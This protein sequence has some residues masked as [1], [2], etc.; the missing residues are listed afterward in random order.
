M[1]EWW[2]ALFIPAIKELFSHDLNCVFVGGVG[3]CLV[4][5]GLPLSWNTSN[6]DLTLPKHF[7][8]VFHFLSVYIYNREIR[9]WGVWLIAISAICRALFTSYMITGY[10]GATKHRDLRRQWQWRYTHFYSRH[11]HFLAQINNTQQ[12]KF[13]ELRG[14]IYNLNFLRNLKEQVK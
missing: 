10:E 12:K 2:I 1:N 7:M 11:K 8:A 6:Q 9:P 14:E 3:F 13:W 4:W 5:A